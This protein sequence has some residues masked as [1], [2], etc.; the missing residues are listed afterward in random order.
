MSVLMGAASAN[1][2]FAVKRSNNKANSGGKLNLVS[3][4]DIF[5]ILVFFLM[6]NTGDVEILQPDEKVVLP[7]SFAQIRPDTSPVIKVSADAIYFKEIMVTSLAD[8][9]APAAKQADQDLIA[10]L[11]QKLLA[12]K[13][14]LDSA[15]PVAQVS[16]GAETDVPER[17]IS[18]MGDSAVPYALLKKVLY[19]CAQA[20]FRDVSLAVEYSSRELHNADTADSASNSAGP[21][22]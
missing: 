15:S 14:R 6:V 3:L 4:M 7:K 8:I 21:A 18:V 1:G 19:T 9:G 2:G 11:Y 20:G 5:T 22:V 10:A 17:A 13:L 12:E 16:L